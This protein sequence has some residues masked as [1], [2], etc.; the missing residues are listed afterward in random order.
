MG[1]LSPYKGASIRF[2]CFGNFVAEND[3]LYPIKSLKSAN[4]KNLGNS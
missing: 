1:D 2:L 4:E 3:I